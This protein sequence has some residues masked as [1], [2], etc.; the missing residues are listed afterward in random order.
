VERARAV[1]P[2]FAVTNENAPAVA[3]ICHRLDGLP[4]AIELAAARARLFTPE[5]LLTRLGSRLRL[6]VGGPRDRPARQ[7]TLRGAIEWSHGLLTP[8]EQALLARLAVFSDGWDLEAAEE[9]CAGLGVDVLAGLETLADQSLV[10]VSDGPRGEPRFGMLETI[11]EFAVERLEASGEAEA[12]RDA[13]AAYFLALAELAEPELRSARAMEWLARL[14][15]EHGNLR[16][17]LDRLLAQQDHERL[18]RACYALWRFWFV[19]GHWG[20]SLRWQ[21]AV[22]DKGAAALTPALR[23][24][25]LLAAGMG[26]ITQSNFA[27]AQAQFEESIALLEQENDTACLSDA[28]W[29]FGHAR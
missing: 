3:E 15:L 22:L 18:A 24:R 10:R 21:E 12:A 13:H 27:Q 20:E 25:M 28:Y 11:R 5:A 19:R 23:G 7:Q 8:A 6:L 4:L 26:H 17:A 2:G 1:R 29:G 9:L 14:E 16:A